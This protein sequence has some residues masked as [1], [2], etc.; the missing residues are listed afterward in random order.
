MQKNVYV[1]LYQYIEKHSVLSF[2][3]GGSMGKLWSL[4]QQSASQPGF[5]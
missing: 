5:L 2:L 3:L 1:S 4:S